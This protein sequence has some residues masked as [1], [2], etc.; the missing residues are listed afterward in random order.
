MEKYP[1][2]KSIPLKH[3]DYSLPGWYYVTICVKRHQCR[4]GE[5]Q[6]GEMS[7]NQIGKI[8]HQEWIYTSDLREYVEL[9]EFVIMPNHLHGIVIIKER[10]PSFSVTKNI[11]SRGVWP[12]TP[13]EKKK[14][15]SHSHSLGSIIRG[16]KSAS[17]KKINKIL[18]TLNKS[19]W[20]RGFHDHIIRNETD[21]WHIRQY[22]SNNPNKWE[23]DRE[24]PDN[25]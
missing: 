10:V 5:I 24:N 25:F 13:T 7:L 8:V 2:R 23:L 20:Q 12:Y 18:G 4:L 11:K 9:D 14:F 6:N 15:E 22:I 16:F 3:Y 21:L 1:E 17:I 19:F